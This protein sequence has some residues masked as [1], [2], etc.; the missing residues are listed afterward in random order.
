MLAL[1]AAA[2]NIPIANIAEFGGH[3]A[4]WVESVR[5]R[6]VDMDLFSTEE[7]AHRQ[8]GELP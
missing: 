2:E 6:R 3:V 7:H 8:H 5:Q 1:F 4:A